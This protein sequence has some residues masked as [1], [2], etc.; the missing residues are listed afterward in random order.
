MQSTNKISEVIPPINESLNVIS[1]SVKITKYMS[2][3]RDTLD[4]AVH[5]HTKAKDK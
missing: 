2:D 3:V 5:G 1:D 4:G